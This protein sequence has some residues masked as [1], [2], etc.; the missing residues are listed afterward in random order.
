MLNGVAS[1]LQINSASS[2]GEVHSSLLN[3]VAS[4]ED[5]TKNSFLVLFLLSL[6]A[7]PFGVAPVRCP[8]IH[9]RVDSTENKLFRQFAGG[10]KVYRK[11]SNHFLHE[12]VPDLLNPD[13]ID[14][15]VLS[16]RDHILDIFF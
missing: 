8:I 6:T 11:K 3:G 13:L 4:E 9:L 5:A 10:K 15:L 2:F 1:L 16:T 7:R 12:Y 14:C